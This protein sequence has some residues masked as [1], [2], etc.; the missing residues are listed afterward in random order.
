MT[1]LDLTPREAALLA[2]AVERYVQDLKADERWASVGVLQGAAEKVF[3]A[4][5][6]GKVSDD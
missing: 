4:T 2:T 5:E 3:G 1:A 6:M